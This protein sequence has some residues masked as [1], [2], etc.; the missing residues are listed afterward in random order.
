M[1]QTETVER[2]FAALEAGGTDLLT[3]IYTDDAK[4][5]H[6]DHSAEQGVPDNL[7]VLKG[8]HAVVSGLTYD[9][10]RRGEVAGGV[11]QQHVLRGTLPDGTEVALPAA[12]F[13][14]VEGERV[15]RIEEYL[16]SSVAAPI[17][18]ARAALTQ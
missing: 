2:F 13:I 15:A 14:T 11:F 18:A 1:S 8:L 10:V 6:N 16:E 7:K 3:T 12:M 5:W 17:R 9:I 4:I